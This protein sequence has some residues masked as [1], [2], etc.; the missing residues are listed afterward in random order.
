MANQLKMAVVNAISTLKERGWSQRRIAQELGIN[1]ETVARY[2]NLGEAGPKPA[3]N[4]PPGSNGSTLLTTSGVSKPAKAPIGSV[5]QDHQKSGP[6]SQCEP[7]GKVIEDKLKVGL[8]RQR[9][10]QDLRDEYG[11]D[12]SY[13]SVRRFVKRLGEDKPI[14]FRRMECMPGDEAQVDFG[15][16]APIIRAD[17][18]RKHPH[19]FRIVLSFSRKAY[20]ETV[21]RQTTD[22]FLHCLENAFWHFWGVPKTLVIEKRGL[23]TLGRPPCSDIQL[24]DGTDCC[25]RPG[26]AGTISNTATTY[27]FGKKIKDR[28]GHCLAA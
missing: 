25:L 28:K 7:F 3:T 26:R 9:I 16:G 21:Y 24:P 13:Y 14:P 5:G 11:F 18:T 27:P 19:V 15:S 8:S 6:E 10:Y 17:G 4:A 23:G 2:V 22:D 20:S 1:R 12:G